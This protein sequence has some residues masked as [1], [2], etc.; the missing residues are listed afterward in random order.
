MVLNLTK[1]KSIAFG[2]NFKLKPQLHLSVKSVLIKQL[3]EIRLI[4]V[5]LD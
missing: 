3:E 5:I 2:S 1:T 4:G